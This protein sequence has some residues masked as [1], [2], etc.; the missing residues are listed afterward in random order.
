VDQLVLVSSQIAGP[1]PFAAGLLAFQAGSDCT[2]PL[3]LAWQTSTLPNGTPLVPAGS[4]ISSPTVANGVAY[5][6]V[7]YAESNVYAVATASGGS[8]TAG[9]VLWRSGTIGT[10]AAGLSLAVVDASVIFD[11]QGSGGS[12]TLFRLPAK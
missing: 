10:C 5:F 8:V 9:Q 12:V 7:G 1:A 4:Y 2:Q 3:S 11:C 6:A